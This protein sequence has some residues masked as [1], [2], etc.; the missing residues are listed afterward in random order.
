MID[1][2]GHAVR[3]YDTTSGTGVAL[4]DTKTFPAP[5][6]ANAN[7]TG[8]A[9]V[10][11]HNGTNYVFAVD[12]NNGVIA[13][14]LTPVTLPVIGSGPNDLT[15]L[16]GG[17]GTVSV[18]ANGSAPL[19]YYWKLNNS[20]VVG[21]FTNNGNLTLTNVTSAN[22]GNYSVVVSNSAG[23]ITS[24]NAAVTI[25]PTVRT[26]AMTSLWRAAGGARAYLS[27][28]DLTRGV[29]ANPTNGHVLVVSRVSGFHIYVL[30]GATGT[31]LWEMNTDSSIVNGSSPGGFDLTL[32]GV[33]DDGAVYACNLNT[34]GANT[35]VYRW[36]DDTT[37]STGGDLRW[38]F[39]LWK[40]W[41]FRGHDGGPGA[42]TNT[43]VLLRSQD[44]S[45]AVM[46]T[47]LDG[48]NFTSTVLNEDSGDNTRLGLAFGAG[49]TYWSKGTSNLYHFAFDLGTG[50]AT[51]LQAFDNAAFPNAGHPI[52]V[53]AVNDLL[54]QVSTIGQTPD[55]LR[56]W[57][58][59]G[60]PATNAVLIDQ[61]FFASDNANINAVGAVSFDVQRGRLFALDNNNGVIALNV[62]ARLKEA[63]DGANVVLTWTGPSV[64]QSATAVTGPY[65]DVSGATSPYT[66]AAVGSVFFRLK[67]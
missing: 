15:I 31:D 30:D 28:S 27:T 47:T 54:A 3:L 41:T 21:V 13:C 18:V 65:T 60:A 40:L 29:A 10:G 23:T 62:V 12:S 19:V 5:A 55:N 67:R 6:T 1:Y 48:F 34:G 33:A 39:E 64:L 25:A 59:I 17:Y 7:G 52:G 26:A 58:I 51:A 16:E 2:A 20:T 46:L 35:K 66:N 11:T 4:Q 49:D 32:V 9:D 61:E 50:A 53:D 63:Y 38:R 45:V 8:A 56:L 22:A 42:G 43:Q 37:N 14:Q 24:T 44:Q 36:D 57:D